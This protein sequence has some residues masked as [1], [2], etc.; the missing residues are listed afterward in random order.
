MKQQIKQIIAAI[1]VFIILI[2]NQACTV[3][4][5]RTAEEVPFEIL[6][7]NDDK[8]IRQY[9]KRVIAMTTVSG[10]YKTAQSQAFRI[11]ADYIFGKNL[12]Q[13]EI[14]M[15]APVTQETKSAKISMTAP[16]TSEK[17]SGG[18]TLTFSMPS[19]YKSLVDLPKP[20]D[21]RIRLVERPGGT[22]AVIQFT[23]LTSEERNQEK[24]KELLDWLKKTGKYE[25]VSAPYY[26]G[27]DP[28]WT[29]PFF[30]R[31]EMLVEVLPL[32][33]DSGDKL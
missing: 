7:K 9:S 28:P 18:W 24:G 32:S 21:E 22:F 29:I 15:T 2:S 33:G 1:G 31:Q 30:R 12:E 10:E 5:I 25:A 16:V 20:I 19:K 17:A 6:E 23:W 27:Y 11:L 3:F 13:Q 4:G 8:E 26:A 14:A